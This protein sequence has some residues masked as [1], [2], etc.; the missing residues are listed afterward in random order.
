M[1][2]PARRGQFARCAGAI[3]VVGAA[4]ALTALGAEASP[5]RARAAATS[6][7]SAAP[8]PCTATAD[9]KARYGWPVRPFDREH[10]LRG[11]FGDP[12]TVERSEQRIDGPR[13]EGSFTFHNGI[14]IVV[15]DGTPVYPVVSGVAVVR[16]SHE[17]SVRT[18]GYRVF[19]YWHVDPLVRTG[20]SV[21]ADE[22]VL[23]TV[24]LHKHHL[25]FGEIDGMRVVNPLAPAHLGPFHKAQAPSVVDLLARSGSGQAMPLNRLHG[26]VELVADAFDRQ[27]LPF[28]GAWSG[29]PVAPALVRWQLE[30]R[31]GA[32]VRPWRTGSDFRL[33]EPP[34]KQF[35]KVYAPGTYQNFPVLADRFDWG[36]PGRYLFRLTPEP[37][38]TAALPDGRYVVVVEAGD[39]CG[40]LG[41]LAQPIAIANRGGKAWPVLSA[42]PLLRTRGA[43]GLPPHRT[44]R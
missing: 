7:A 18:R 20:Q 39:V 26:D 11:F 24:Q 16:H 36:K 32:V 27:P 15:A 21:I 6:V 1:R 9:A 33:H 14:D 41:K 5:P 10:P 31:D 29:K 28:W 23:G 42:L 19:Q 38:D 8:Q 13:S 35:W 43:L 4:L 34:P 17:V 12:R 30:R 25:H 22:T 37:I 2:R 40:N 3:V 44:A